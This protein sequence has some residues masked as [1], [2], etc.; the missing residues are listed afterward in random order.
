MTM[1]PQPETKSW[2]NTLSL[3]LSALGILVFTLLAALMAI[4]GTSMSGFLAVPEA[5]LISV[6]TLA[7][8]SLLCA[9]ALIPAFLLSLRQ[10]RGQPTPAWLDM[11]AQPKVRKVILRSIL[12][13]PLAVFAGWQVT[14]SPALARFLLGP[15]NLLVAG[16]PVLWLFNL[17]QWKLKGGSPLRKWRIFGFSLV[18]TPALIMVLEILAAVILLGGIGLWWSARGALDPDLQQTLT[19]LMDQISA[20]SEDLDA[21]VQS[22]EPLLLQPA[23]IAW[24][25]AVFAGVMPVIEEVVKPLALWALAGKRI[26]EAEGFVGGLLAGAGFA[27]LENVLFFTTATGADDWLFLAVGRAGTGMLHMLSSGLVGWGLAKMWREGQWFQQALATLGAIALHGLWNVLSLA[28]GVLPF[29][30]LE[31]KMT[32]AQT[33]LAYLPTIAL[34][35]SSAL[36]ILVINRRLRGHGE[37]EEPPAIILPPSEEN[38]T[39]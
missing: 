28:S 32:L 38:W 7:W 2:Q 13:W 35:I 17:A 5:Q 27:L 34:L 8:A 24:G 15:I 25:L 14:G 22:L 11:Q 1:A 20:G 36:A 9:L 31:E 26:T 10:W 6:G 39:D 37:D 23:V 16:L 19:K 29:A 21:V 18:V 30:T 3:A 33:I 12:L 4:F